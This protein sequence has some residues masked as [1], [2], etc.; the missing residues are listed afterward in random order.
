MNGAVRWAGT[1]TLV[2]LALRRDRIVL[3]VWIA[4]FVGL[5]LMSASASI[6]LFPDEASRIKAGTA[7]NNSPALIAMYGRVYDVTSLGEVSMLKM[8]GLY[9]LFLAVL[10]FFTLVRHTRADEESGRLELVGAGV[11]GRHAALTAALIVT[12]GTGILIGLLTAVGLIAVGLPVAGSIAFG[13]GWASVAC[14]AATI[15]A[16]A[17]QVTES[18]RAANGIAATVLG[19]SYVIRAVG[20]SSGP[21]WLSWF[22]PLGWVLQVRPYAG[23][24]FWVFGLFAVFILAAGWASYALVARR[25]LGAGLIRPRPGPPE[26]AGWLRSPLALAW[27][28]QRGS[29]LA[30]T[31]GFVLIGAVL[32]NIA[33][34]IGD[35]LDSKS[36]RELVQ[37]MGGVS[38]LTDAFFAAELGILAVVASAYGVQAALRLR[39]EE[40]TQRAEPLLATAVSR[41]SWALSHLT[42][43]FFG[44]AVLVVAAGVGAGLAHGSQTGDMGRAFNRVVGAALVQIPAVWV[45]VAIVAALYGLLPRWSS[46][47]WVL[48]VAFLLLGEFGSLFEL[49]QAV[50]DLSPY[51]H[52]PNLPGG[53]MAVLPLIW[54]TLIAAALTVAGVAGFRRRD[55]TT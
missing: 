52:V 39:S 47:A 23:N 36:S 37:K 45:L 22:S 16:V 48:L 3:P 55:I 49:R 51:A 46:F 54:L 9:A 15:A 44:T 41:P 10:A 6:A 25:D 13:C 11:V 20:D 5:A 29:L 35:I 31:V 53:Q 28:L 24:R 14:A 34:S 12:C 27:R 50:M 17:A 38:G 33:A 32:G 40:T 7:I 30:W 1:A 19:V 4:I 2:R 43:A 42:V 8:K 26:A 21:E 18:A